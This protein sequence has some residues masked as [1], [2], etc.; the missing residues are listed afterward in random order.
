MQRRNAETPKYR[1]GETQRSGC[2]TPLSWLV[3]GF[4]LGL[5]ILADCDLDVAGR[6]PADHSTAGSGAA[7]HGEFKPD[8]T[9]HAGGN[10]KINNWSFTSN[11]SGWAVGGLAALGWFVAHGGRKKEAKAVEDVVTAIEETHCA[12]C[13]ARVAGRRNR[14]VNQRVRQLTAKAI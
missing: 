14:Y 2:W 6:K 1:D 9:V 5:M 7:V 11:D 8:T 4:I 12:E 3:I 10:A 13:K